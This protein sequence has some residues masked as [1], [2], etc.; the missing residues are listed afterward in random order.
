MKYEKGTFVTVPNIQ[1]LQEL[2]PT[3]QALFMWLCSYADSAGEC[4]P[5]RGLLAEN[6]SC[7]V[8]AIDTHMKQLI[9]AGFIEKQTRF[10]NNE[11]TSNTYQILLVERCAESAPPPAQNLHPP[12]AE[13]A[14][15]TKPIEPNPIE[16]NKPEVSGHSLKEKKHHFGELKNVLLTVEEKD[17]LIERYGHSVAKNYTEK[18]SLY[19]ASR[20]RAYK[21]HYAV[22]RS[23]ALR[24][25]AE[26][27]QKQPDPVFPATQEV[28]PEEQE[29]IT[30]RKAQIA[31]SLK[32]VHN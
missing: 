1:A 3:S 11:Q 5:S 31:R 19:L 12:S 20:G 27:I 17:K 4:Y 13:S 2:P 29:K 26:V 21:S 10:K 8:R 24:D 14:H 22:I 9:T 7:S 32:G 15:R 28:S 6:L 16:L 30:K 25:K 18:L 23:W